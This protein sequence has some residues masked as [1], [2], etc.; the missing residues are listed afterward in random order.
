MK[1]VLGYFRKY[2]TQSILSPI[3]KLSEATFELIVPLVIASIIDKGI[4][5]SDM[6]VVYKCV[7]LLGVFALVGFASAICAQYFAAAAA[8]GISSDIRSDLF[9]KINHIS[10]TDFERIGRSN[11]VTGLTSDV[12]QIQ[13]GINLFLR[14]LLRSPFIVIGAVVMAFTISV[15]LTMIFVV[16]VALLGVFVALNMRMAI[17][18]Y[19][20]TRKGLDSLV[21]VTDNG[22]SGVKVIRGFNRSE[23]DYELFVGESENLKKLQN[24]AS[25]ISSYLNPVTFM[26]IN[27]AICLLIYKGAINVSSGSLSQGQVVALY[28]Y[29]SQI[30]VELI[31]LANLIVSVS[32]AIA[33]A[34]RVENIL[35]LVDESTVKVGRIPNPHEAHSIEFRDV[36]F[37]FSGNSEETLD[38]ISFS[39]NAGETIGIIGKTGSGKSTVAQ[40][41]AGLYPVDNGE[42]LIDGVPMDNISKSDLSK[43]IGL[44]LQKAKMFSGSIKYNIDLN[45]DGVTKEDVE[46]AVT[47]SCTD[48]VVNSKPNKLMHKVSPNGAGLSGGQK[49]RIGIARVLAGKP[50]ILILDD[51]TSALDASTERRLVNNLKNLSYKP[52]K[53]IISQKIRTVMNADRILIIDDGKV[54]AF[55]PHS[56]LMEIS[57]TYKELYNLQNKEDDHE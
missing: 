2:K 12:N 28:N 49:Q 18:A 22:L 35:T 45:R 34:G 3:F 1:T 43:A 19:K 55:A 7:L 13:S 54:E 20:D 46:D 23:D 10:V 52:T 11:I 32:R 26:I 47:A 21:A 4:A 40:L 16:A 5:N 38:N 57:P 17:P 56:E 50:G 15:K 30:L 42:I 41:A 6:G 36:S 9:R 24:K 27:L 37:T 51:S 14:L 25:G 29:M 39:V 33:C 8:A 53:L 31:K 48:D 44:C